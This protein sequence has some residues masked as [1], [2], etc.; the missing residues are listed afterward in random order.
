MCWVE[1]TAGEQT[2]WVPVKR[3]LN[4]EAS[5]STLTTTGTK[6]GN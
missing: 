6:S 5:D 4:K 1:V 3:E 2:K